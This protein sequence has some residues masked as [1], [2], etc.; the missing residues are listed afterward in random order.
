[1]SC[2]NQYF[3]VLFIL[4]GIVTL[5]AC[6]INREVSSEDKVR[7]D[8]IIEDQYFK[9][10]AEFARPLATN[11]LNQLANAGLF[12]PGDNPSQINLQGNSN[13]F[14]FEGDSVSA[15]LPYFGERQMGGGYNENSGI[16]FKGIPKDLKINKDESKNLY[17]INFYMKQES[18]SYQI[19]LTLY[20]NLK[21]SINVNSSQRFPIRY[22]G[23]LEAL[24]IPVEKE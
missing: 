6:S 3:K 16:E 15:Y 18:E 11:A 1:M 7:L 5:F 21:A 2:K 4:L 12:R 20:S 10:E 8:K 13:F 22:D 9:I 17:T 23:N 14:K 24:D 19:S